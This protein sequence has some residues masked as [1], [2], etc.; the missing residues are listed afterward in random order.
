[1]AQ[2]FAQA[3]ALSSS[4]RTLIAQLLKKE[5]V[6]LSRRQI[7][8]RRVDD[9]SLPLSFSQQRLWFLNQLSPDNSTHNI[10]SYRKLIGPLNVQALFRS[11]SEILRRHEILRTTFP[12]VDGRPSQFIAP[13]VQLQLPYVDLQHLS[14]ESR[15]LEMKRLCKEEGRKPFD[16]AHGP[17]LR[18][19]LLKLSETEHVLIQVMHHIIADGLS[20]GIFNKEMSLMYQAF[21]CDSPHMLSELPIQYADFAKWQQQSLKDEKVTELL[22]YWKQHLE[23]APAVLEF[24]LQRERAANHSSQGALHSFAFSRQLTDRL[25]FLSRRQGVSLFMTLLAGFNS[26]LYRYTKQC[27]MVVGCPVANRTRAEVEELV[28]CFINTLALRTRI[29]ADQTFRQLL[30][31]VRETALGGFAHQDCPFEMVV[32]AL[33]PERSLSH[34]PLFQVMFVLQTAQGPRLTL[35]DVEIQS[36][37]LQDCSA[38]Y[39]LTLSAW[40]SDEGIR[41]TWLYNK[42][43]FDAETIE[44]LSQH[45]VIMMEGAVADADSAISELPLLTPDEQ[46][47]QLC[48]WNNTHTEFPSTACFQHLFEA[49]VERTPD[50]L[51]VV[52][53]NS[54]ISYR[55]LN[56]RANQLAHHLRKQG[57]GPE[58][59]VSLLM[60]RSIEM[61]IGL[62]GILKAGGAYVPLD[63]SHPKHRL[64]FILENTASLM[65]L[66]QQHLDL[67]L[68]NYQGR[69]LHLDA[70]F[71]EIAQ[72]SE[73]NPEPL[74]TAENLAY[75]IYTSGST[76]WPKGVQVRH[77][78]LTNFLLS[79]GQQ[80]GINSADTLLAVT[81][82]SFDIAALELFLPLMYAAPI[83]IVSRAES[84]DG[85]VLLNLLECS[86]ATIMQATPATWRLLLMSGWQGNE[87]L[88]VL[89]GGEALDAELGRKLREKCLALWNLYGPTETTI[90]SAA[91]E[92]ESVQRSI[93]I[94]R[95]IANT[96]L[97]IL[98]ERL[99]PLPFGTPG[100]LYIG[101]TGLARGYQLNP[102]LTAEKFIPDPFS[103][104]QGARLYKTGDVTRYLPDGRIEFIGRID[105]Q[106]KIRGYRIELG[107]IAARLAEHPAVSEA[108]VNVFEEAKGDKRLVAYLVPQDASDISPQNLRRHLLERLPEYMLPSTY[109]VLQQ[110]PLTPNGKVDL[111]A[112]PPPDRL[113]SETGQPFVAPRTPVEEK[114]AAIWSGVLGIEAVGIHHNFFELGG[115]S[116]LATQVISRIRE[117]FQVTI[118]LRQLFE[119]PT[120]CELAE[121]IVQSQAQQADREKID[122]LLV[123]LEHLSQEEAEALLAVA[124]AN[125]NGAS[126][127]PASVPSEL[128]EDLPVAQRRLLS[129][130]FE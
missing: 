103:E 121:F 4:R 20:L 54:R 75:V 60:N 112:L 102:A 76:G 85:E 59:L 40:E 34:S 123:L 70:A 61:L 44:R 2:H 87:H 104:Q 97:Y 32:E 108:A 68:P 95:P 3:A 113:Q 90:W 35:G 66:T 114:L 119:T 15:E 45:F 109:V 28:G 52:Y 100:D 86:G 41:G 72:E 124:A 13:H 81:P 62:L 25:N 89:C 5:G 74:N 46:Q 88:K 24:P 48:D 118:A 9:S 98:D 130:L 99:Q 117:T 105:H 53:G 77:G 94:G 91:Y 37:P 80:L 111:K 67:D 16:L 31:Q 21:T 64:N 69:V 129:Q 49:Q 7:I 82:L 101:G 50:A 12:A 43:L 125:T 51:A 79:M 63:P 11:I 10:P 115:H 122:E 23:G 22:D 84:M 17:L 1:M 55:E 92:V 107:G 8:P 39:M 47:L 6:N 93:P 58:V 27:D 65:L 106:V 56:S 29:S 120:I 110:M 71:E 116:L 127:P 126:Q 128:I 42:S 19:T 18:I 26:L 57:V 73:S 36:L 30:D 33:Q 38:E 83:F 14:P 78:A 96:Q